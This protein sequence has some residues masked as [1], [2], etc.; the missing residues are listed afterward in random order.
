MPSLFRA[1]LV[2][3]SLIACSAFADTYPLRETL[4]PPA[5]TNQIGTRVGASVAIDGDYIAVG[6]PGVTIDGVTGRGTASIHSAATGELLAHLRYPPENNSPSGEFGFSVAISGRRAVVGAWRRS[7]AFVYDLDG[8]TPSLPLLALQDPTGA[9]ARGSP[10]SFGYS[11]AISG[12]LFVIGAPHTRETERKLGA[13]YIY[14]LASD[15]PDSPILVLLNPDLNEAV[16]D[17]FGEAIAVSGTRLVV[18][19][20][21]DA[22]GT[23]NT[24]AAYVYDL[25]GSSPQEPL[26]LQHDTT[27]HREFFGS[28]VAIAG[29]RVVVGTADAT[30]ARAAYLYDLASSSPAI[31]T[32]IISNPDPTANAGVVALHG[33]SLVLGAPRQ[34]NSTG[35][36][37]LYD[38]QSSTSSPIATISNPQP[39][40][41]DRFGAAVAISGTH[42]VVA[43]PG[44]DL[45]RGAVDIFNRNESLAAPIQTLHDYYPPVQDNLGYSL[46]VA[47]G[48][49]V[50]S[51]T[52][53]DAAGANAGAVY[54]Y[55]LYGSTPSVPALVLTPAPDELGGYGSYVSVS[56][57][58]VAVGAPGNGAVGVPSAGAAFVYNLGG[59]FPGARIKTL[60]EPTPQ[61]TSRFGSVVAVSGNRVAVSTRPIFNPPRAYLFDLE[62]PTPAVPLF[63]FSPPSGQSSSFAWAIA[64]S[65]SRLAIGDYEKVYLYDIDSPSPTVPTAT[66]YNPR[67]YTYGTF[68][69]SIALTN[70]RLIVGTS[71]SGFT[72]KPFGYYQAGSAYVYNLLDPFL[73]PL[74]LQN[75]DSYKNDGFGKQ[76]SIAGS[77]A[78]VGRGTGSSYVYELNGGSPASP[79]A[80]LN[81]AP[82]SLAN[83]E[84]HIFIGDPYVDIQDLDQGAVF[85]FGRPLGPMLPQI[86]VRDQNGGWLSSGMGTVDLGAVPTGERI[87]RFFTITNT[88]NANLE[89]ITVTIDELAMDV[90]E[91][92][93]ERNATL[94]PGAS[95]AFGLYFSSATPGYRTASLRITSNDPVQNRFEIAAV[96]R[97]LNEQEAWRNHY[98][99]DPDGLGDGA[100][101]ADGD[102]DGND[103]LFEF[104]AGLDPTDPLS[105]FRI[106]IEAGPDVPTQRAIVFWPLVAGRTYE[107]K[108]KADLSDA[109]WMPLSGFT[110]SD[111]D[112]ER[113]VLDL[114]TGARRR[115]Y[116]VE[117]A[118]P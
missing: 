76:V 81:T 23:T 75:P 29:D 83:S 114:S 25:G 45:A 11:V 24:G 61:H 64:L 70:S 118:K 74:I 100:D 66:I 16:F 26:V 73:Q 69:Y 40:A 65:G 28:L 59:D 43:R 96:A 85:V 22:E 62:S 12:N 53:D 2:T 93:G 36:A 63:T 77:L 71:S 18:G 14:D 60:R 44:D 97:S 82:A 27:N 111:T 80:V 3:R 68:G 110:S 88:G 95:S 104:T 7:I 112:D 38:L 103:N 48:R 10:T 8:A 54:V 90:F 55:E 92:T 31:A 57:N 115:I 107:V 105:R 47:D 46:A 33:S 17:T 5:T 34:D 4:L 35:V 116:R 89:E 101:A 15:T 30:N 91:V 19:A 32:N 50:V 87:E 86:A 9:P 49:L 102:R 108:V 39:N 52:G 99:A 13:V 1:L 51:A 109:E 58:Y 78:V 67:D 79:A 37:Y 98:F 84:E 6:A 21:R 72:S 113:T 106:R 20:P 42:V 56:A 117:I 41:S 94:A